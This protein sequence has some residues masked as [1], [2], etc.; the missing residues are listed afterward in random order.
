MKVG[1][2]PVS[3]QPRFVEICGCRSGPGKGVAVTVGVCSTGGVPVGLG[4][5]VADPT[6]RKLHDLEKT[7][8]PVDACDRSWTRSI[9]VV[10]AIR[11]K[12][13]RVWFVGIVPSE[14]TFT[15]PFDKKSKMVARVC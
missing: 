2:W 3:K 6:T 12:N 1:F 14:K 9:P 7:V 13:V 5:G 10:G 15:N 4:D 11:Q 8:S